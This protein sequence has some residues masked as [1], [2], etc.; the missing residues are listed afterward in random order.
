MQTDKDAEKNYLR[1][2]M[3]HPRDEPVNR[4]VNRREPVDRRASTISNASSTHSR[5]ETD[6]NTNI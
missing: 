1:E 6:L 2:K 5:L 3:M 4:P